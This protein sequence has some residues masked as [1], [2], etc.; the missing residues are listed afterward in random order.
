M[1]PHFSGA[2]VSF[3]TEVGPASVTAAYPPAT[4]ERLR[5]I[6]GEVDPGNVFRDNA[7]IEPA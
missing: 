4:L 5:A 3:E 6:K 2:Y 1:A 7:N